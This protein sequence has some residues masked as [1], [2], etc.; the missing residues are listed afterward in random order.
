MRLPG[1]ESEI[2]SKETVVSYTIAGA[3]EQQSNLQEEVQSLACSVKEWMQQA[4]NQQQL[5][6][7]FRAQLTR[8]FSAHDE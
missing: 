3:K 8:E 2:Q 1:G 4:D 7:D 6:T 5:L